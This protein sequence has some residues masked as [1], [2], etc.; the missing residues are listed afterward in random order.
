MTCFGRVGRQASPEHLAQVRKLA[1]ITSLELP[2]IMRATAVCGVCGVGRRIEAQLAQEGVATAWDLAKMDPATVKRRWSVALERSV[3][4]L[5]GQ[6]CTALED[7]PS[8]KTG[9][10]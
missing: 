8:E 7:A 6:S 3:L 4:E 9:A 10:P 5:Q 2:E 1:D